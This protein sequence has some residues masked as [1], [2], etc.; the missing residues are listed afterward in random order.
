MTMKQIHQEFSMALKLG[1]AIRGDDVELTKSLIQLGSNLNYEEYKSPRMWIDNG[2][3]AIELA[4]LNHKT[5]HIEVLVKAGAKIKLKVTNHRSIL[6]DLLESPH[7]SADL[8]KTFV[9]HMKLPDSNY[10]ESTGNVFN[11]PLFH[12]LKQKKITVEHIDY[13]VSL[14]IPLTYTNANGYINAEALSTAA[15]H[16]NIDILKSTF[17][18]SKALD[19]LEHHLSVALSSAIKEK[20]PKNVQFLIDKGAKLTYKDTYDVTRYA[21][22]TAGEENSCKALGV[23]L[24]N[25]GDINQLNNYGQTSLMRACYFTSKTTVDFLL[26]QG[27]D[28]N[29]KDNEGFTALHYAASSNNPEIIKA[30]IAY[31]ANKD[32]Q[33]IKGETPMMIA[34]HKLKMKNLVMFITCGCD[35]NMTDEQGKTALFYRSNIKEK[36]VLT[37]LL[38]AGAHIDHQ[39]NDGNTP[40]L[41]EIQKK[42]MD[43]AR[44]LLDNGADVKITNN[45]GQTPNDIFLRKKIV[46]N[47]FQET[48]DYINLKTL[49]VDNDDEDFSM[50]L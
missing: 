38:R 9:S 27:A 40:L 15:E 13:L 35:V 19:N 18:H 43:G 49:V 3:T 8:L 33:N 37:T 34:A 12:A 2:L 41:N 14:G 16:P 47:G 31:G 20:S 42:S 45:K 7:C 25:N 24:K 5:N 48:I 10:F 28:V 21:M 29:L 17:E 1:L 11:N 22:H 30:L 39:D 4:I 6:N 50:G 36:G 26:E 23:L 46:P 32:P 44:V